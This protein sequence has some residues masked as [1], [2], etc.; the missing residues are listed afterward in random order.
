MINIKLINTYQ[1]PAKHNICKFLGKRK[2]LVYQEDLQLST[3]VLKNLHCCMDNH[4]GVQHLSC[5][6]TFF[7]CFEDGVFAPN[8]YRNFVEENLINKKTL[9]E[10]VLED[11]N[12]GEWV[13][14]I[15]DVAEKIV[16]TRQV[17]SDCTPEITRIDMSRPSKDH[18]DMI[19]RF[20][21]RWSQLQRQHYNCLVSTTIPT[22]VCKVP[23]MGVGSNN[24]RMISKIL[25]GDGHH[26]V[27]EIMLPLELNLSRD[28]SDSFERLAG[29]ELPRELADQLDNIDFILCGQEITV[30]IVEVW[31]YIQHMVGVEIKPPRTINI[32]ELWQESGLWAAKDI[33][34]PLINF[35]LTGAVMCQSTAVEE[36]SSYHRSLDNVPPV[37]KQYLLDKL[38]AIRN[39]MLGFQICFIPQMFPDVSEVREYSNLCIQD[40]LRIISS[41]IEVNFTYVVPDNEILNI[42]TDEPYFFNQQEVQRGCLL[43][44][45]LLD[46]DTYGKYTGGLKW[47]KGPSIEG[48]SISVTVNN[49]DELLDSVDEIEIPEEAEVYLPTETDDYITLKAMTNAY[50]ELSDEEN[51]KKWIKHNSHE[52]LRLL[53]RS[54]KEGQNPGLPRFAFGKRQK[55]RLFQ[56]TLAEVGITV[57]YK[58]HRKVRPPPAIRRHVDNR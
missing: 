28:N 4:N 25:M 49:I 13:E 48:K 36:F 37:V 58:H 5:A 55:V 50:P 17:E 29:A 24:G 18:G 40:A 35:Y 31:N 7:E 34:I 38:V 11:K 14:I 22:I 44:F 56:E 53:K 16:A 46:L 6:T 33:S 1:L 3:G 15:G 54:N 26:L 39:C 21:A 32:E 47:G 20:F 23:G 41:A 12:A 10:Q 45:S 27:L 51:L 2:A 9:L 43:E 8:S 42:A 30:D 52:A 19:A 57:N